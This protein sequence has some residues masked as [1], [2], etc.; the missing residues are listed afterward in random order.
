MAKTS[1]LRTREFLEA[2]LPCTHC[3]TQEVLLNR[4][5]IEETTV[6]PVL[7]QASFDGQAGACSQVALECL[8]VVA[9]RS[10]NAFNPLVVETNHRPNPA[11]DAEQVENLRILTAL[12]GIQVLSRDTKLF[13]SDQGRDG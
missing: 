8:S 1:H 12:A 13:R 6:P 7:V 9:D 3:R 10:D 4:H 11:I 5:R 2:D